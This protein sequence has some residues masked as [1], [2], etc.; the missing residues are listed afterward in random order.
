[1]SS[2]KG[3]NMLISRITQKGQITIPKNIREALR[4]EPND[5]VVFVRRGNDIFIKPVKDVL[6]I[7]GSV[8]VKNTKEYTLERENTRTKVADRVAN[9]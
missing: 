8:K 4:L 6:T 9:E 7:R 2:I 3:K 1:M 5:Q